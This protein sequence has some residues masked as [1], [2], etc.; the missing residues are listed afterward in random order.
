[1]ASLLGAIA[2]G[3][4][5]MAGDY[6]ML[7]GAWPFTVMS[8][9]MVS[10]YMLLTIAMEYFPRKRNI[11][12]FLA[13]FKVMAFLMLMFGYPKKYFG[14]FQNVSFNLVILDYAPI[15][16]LLLGMNIKDIIQK[17]SPA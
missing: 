17:K 16:L 8:M 14:E 1:M 11:I 3:V 10:F 15:M 6:P 4:P 13:Y 5:H 2:H 9:G 7:R 12:F